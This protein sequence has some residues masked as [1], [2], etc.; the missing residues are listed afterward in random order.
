MG[1]NIKNIVVH[2]GLSNQGLTALNREDYERYCMGIWHLNEKEMKEEKKV[3]KFLEIKEG[4]EIDK[5][6]DKYFKERKSIIENDKIHKIL[7]KAEQEINEIYKEENEREI[8]ISHFSYVT[9]E[10]T[11]KLNKLEQENSKEIKKVKEKYAEIAALVEDVPAKDRIPI[12]MQ[13][14]IM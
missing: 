2:S 9:A 3:N 12:Y 4:Q 8:S 10:N 6:N 11:E 1:E 7:L 13:Y 14:E 5:I